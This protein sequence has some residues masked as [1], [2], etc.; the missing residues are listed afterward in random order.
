MIG[1]RVLHAIGNST[2]QLCV[3]ARIIHG[4]QLNCGVYETL[5]HCE[6]TF[7]LIYAILPVQC[8]LMRS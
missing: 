7:T 2:C 1:L 6:G 3:C 8:R 5:V 4:Q